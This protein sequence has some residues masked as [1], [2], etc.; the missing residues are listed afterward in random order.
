MNK[1]IIIV[2]LLMGLE[3]SILKMID[4]RINIVEAF[5]E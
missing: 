5:F 2:F 1:I 3:S 4:D